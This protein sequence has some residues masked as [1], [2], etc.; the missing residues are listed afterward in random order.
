MSE[1]GDWCRFVHKSCDK[2]CEN[3]TCRA[4]F[5]LKQPWI[6][7]Y[8]LDFCL[9]GL[10]VECLRREEAL[11]WREQKRLKGLKEKCPFAH[12]TV[13]GKPWFWM[14]K[15]GDI[16]FTLTPFEPVNE[17]N[18]MH[19]K[20]DIN[21]DIIYTYDEGKFTRKDVEETCLSGNPEIYG[22]CPNYI[23]GMQVHME[24]AETQEER[25]KN[26]ET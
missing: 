12:N 1:T 21:G 26:R 13:C 8:D 2:N 18:P 7:P 24:Y 9:S 11:E 10:H 25:I 23:R 19:P 16:P 15:G 3:Y 6:A 22:K 4:F 14:C 20:R 5:P 17:V